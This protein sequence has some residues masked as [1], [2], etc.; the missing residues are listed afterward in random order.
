MDVRVDIV[1]QIEL[2]FRHMM[3]CKGTLRRH[4]NSCESVVRL[5]N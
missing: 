1:V 3:E 5:R 4:H 2:V